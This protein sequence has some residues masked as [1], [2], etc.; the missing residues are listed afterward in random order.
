[1]RNAVPRLNERVNILNIKACPGEYEPA[2]FALFALED[3]Q[4]L[5][6]SV[7]NLKSS[8]DVIRSDAIDLRSV[9]YM[10]RAGQGRWGLFQE[11][12]M[13]DIPMFLEKKEEISITK[14]NNQLLW[15]TVKVPQNARPG[16]Y[17]GTVDIETEK[18]KIQIPVNL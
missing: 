9:H 6:I 17:S 2:T 7:S 14:G 13:H 1:M 12:T 18:T 15:L 10:S 11:T 8:L 3:I 4:D 5:N 16:K